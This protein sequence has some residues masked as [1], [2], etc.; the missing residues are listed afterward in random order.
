VGLGHAGHHLGEAEG[1]AL[2]LGEER[3]LVPDRD[4]VDALRGLSGGGGIGAVGVD[5]VGAAVDLGGPQADQLAKAGRE[6][7]PV[8]LACRSGVIALLK[9]GAAASTS[10]RA[11]TWWRVSCWGTS[12]VVVMAPT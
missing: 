3:R 5:A 8:E 10:R 1:S 4:G 9:A 6:A 2:A 11:G 7:D 12:E